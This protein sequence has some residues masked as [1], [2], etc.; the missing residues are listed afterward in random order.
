MVG[1]GVLVFFGCHLGTAGL[2]HSVYRA[3]KR[4]TKVLDLPKKKLRR[5]ASEKKT[6][7]DFG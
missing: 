6:I 1:K 2:L 3:I 7:I 5:R 4:Q